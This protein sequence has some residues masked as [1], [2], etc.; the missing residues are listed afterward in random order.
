MITDLNRAKCWVIEQALLYET[1]ENFPNK[2]DIDK[3][4][5]KQGYDG[6]TELRIGLDTEYYEKRIENLAEQARLCSWR[7]LYERFVN[8]HQRDLRKQQ[9][10]KAIAAGLL[11]KYKNPKA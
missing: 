5:I 6:G 7:S 9:L 1:L 4:E 2:E 8:G 3:S 11:E 10:R